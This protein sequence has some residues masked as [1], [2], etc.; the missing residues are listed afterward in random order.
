MCIKEVWIS[1]AVQD[2]RHLPMNQF[3]IKQ[4]KGHKCYTRGRQLYTASLF[5]VYKINDVDE[6]SFVLMYPRWVTGENFARVVI[7]LG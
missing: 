6:I 2:Q 3:F 5:V 7:L 1:E 4:S